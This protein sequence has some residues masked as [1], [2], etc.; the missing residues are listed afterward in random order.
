MGEIC[1]VTNKKQVQL[2]KKEKMS[3]ADI[4]LSPEGTQEALDEIAGVATLRRQRDKLLAAC[5]EA[6]KWHISTCTEEGI[7]AGKLEE[8]LQHAISNCKVKQNEVEEID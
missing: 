6:Y 2:C 1:N 8:M 3:L 7:E 5:E 4:D